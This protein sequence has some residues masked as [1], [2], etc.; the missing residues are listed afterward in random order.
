MST[1]API[2]DVADEPSEFVNLADDRVV[3][4]Q[5]LPQ[6]RCRHDAR[7]ASIPIK[8]LARHLRHEEPLDLAASVILTEP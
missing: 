7:R 1:G 5:G 4:L 2:G 3:L 6:R 8:H